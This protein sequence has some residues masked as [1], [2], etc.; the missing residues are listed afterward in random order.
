MYIH[1]Y[2]GV[3][4]FQGSVYYLLSELSNFD[5]MRDYLVNEHNALG[6]ISHPLVT[7]AKGFNLGSS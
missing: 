2:Q 4:E 7:V 1:A 3:D 6:H 5:N